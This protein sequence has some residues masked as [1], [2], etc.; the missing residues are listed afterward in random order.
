MNLLLASV[1]I[2]GHKVGGENQAW[3]IGA[4]RTNPGNAMKKKAIRLK[5]GLLTSNKSDGLQVDQ[6][7]GLRKR[8]GPREKLV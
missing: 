3:P 5:I 4:G 2:G 7:G 1:L 6:E 8:A